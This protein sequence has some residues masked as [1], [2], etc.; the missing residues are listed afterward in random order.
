MLVGLIPVF[1]NYY[2]YRLIAFISMITL[3]IIRIANGHRS[4]PS[5]AKFSGLPSLFG[6]SIY[7][8]MC[9]HSLP[10]IVTPIRQKK[11]VYWLL[12]DDF[13]VVL[14]FYLVLSITGAIAFEPSEMHQL[15]TLD[16]FNPRDSIPRLVVGTYLAL[17]PVF[18]LSASF[19]I[20]TVTLR[21]NLKSLGKTILKKWRGDKD[22]PFIVDRILFPVLVLTPPTI[23]AYSIQQDDLL[24]SVTG[25]FPGVGVQ[26]LIP[27]ALVFMARYTLKKKFRTYKNKYKSP[28]SNIIIIGLVLLWAFVSVILIIINMSITPPKQVKHPI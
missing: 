16:F 10:G 6:I 9:Q 23:I 1:M 8:F 4:L 19:P 14:L 12:G 25:S 18:T 21:E 11:G 24:V 17:F 28:F 15:Y 5:M 7:S 26:Y 13:I 3:A 22:F 2:K 20:I 27:T